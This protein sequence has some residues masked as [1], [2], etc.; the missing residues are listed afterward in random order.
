MSSFLKRCLLAAP[1]LVWATSLHAASQNAPAPGGLA[2][3]VA[4]ATRESKPAPE[5]KLDEGLRAVAR[6][7][8]RLG[9]RGARRECEARQIP[10]VDMRL[11]AVI[12]LT[13]DDQRPKVERAL[14]KAWGEVLAF[15]DG[16]LYVRLP[17]PAIRRM[18]QQTAVRAITL[19]T[20]LDTAGALQEK[21]R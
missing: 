13:S 5:S 2:Q 12:H 21:R 11:S 1:L 8:R 18:S 9:E 6:E 16:R 17:V 3:A 4:E 15:H 7:W 14:R 19:D 20:Q 10:L